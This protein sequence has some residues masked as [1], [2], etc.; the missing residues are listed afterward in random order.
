MGHGMSTIH[1]ILLV[2]LTVRAL[3]RIEAVAFINTESCPLLAADKE[4]ASVAAQTALYL[5]LR[6]NSPSIQALSLSCCF[7]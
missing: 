3:L 7:S 5:L 2:G 1:C 6:I 4:A